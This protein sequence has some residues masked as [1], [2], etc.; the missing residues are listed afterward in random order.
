[1]EFRYLLPYAE[2]M[3][4]HKA[5]EILRSVTS[6]KLAQADHRSFEVQQI[7]QGFEDQ[8]YNLEPAD[9]DVDQT[10]TLEQIKATMSVLNMEFEVVG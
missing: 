1:M 9:T 8:A 3:T 7:M 5:Q 6:G 10:M 2:E 4:R